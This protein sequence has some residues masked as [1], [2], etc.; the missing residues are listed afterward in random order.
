MSSWYVFSALGMYPQVPSRADLV[1][2]A[3]VFPHAVV[4][5]GLGRTI[6]VNAPQASEKNIY[7]QGLRTNG[8]NSDKPWVPASFVT[9]GGTLDYT[10]GSTPDTSWGSSPKDAPPSFRDGEAPFFASTA[11]GSVKIEPGGSADS[12]IE[13]TTIQDKKVDVGWT[14][15]PPAGITLTPAAGRVTVPKNGAASAKLSVSVAEGTKSGVYAIPIT[16]TS[17][18][19]GDAPPASLSVTVGVRG[20]VTWYV[21]NAG[22]SADD[23]NPAA[24][25]DGEGWSYSAAALAAA[26]ATPGGTV[27]AA[28]FEFTWPQVSPGA[29]DNIVVGGG[30]QVVD[31]AKTSAGATKLSLLGSASEG[32][33]TGTVTLTYTDGSTEQAQIGFSDWTLGGGSQQPSYG[34]VVAVHTTYRDVQ[35]GGKDPVG[36]EVFATAPIALQPGKQLASVTLPATTD[37]GDMHVFAVATA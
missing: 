24:N 34:N 22:I 19:G 23:G 6:T 14:A 32:Q 8:R 4:H 27:S 10:L 17:S 28:G 2:S 3:P 13:L 29:P 7:I 35:G 33:T 21:N 30:D 36:T 9:R 5:T 31:V 18:H 37:G 1:L 26:G 25:F 12:A 20:T 11:P 15:K 16:L